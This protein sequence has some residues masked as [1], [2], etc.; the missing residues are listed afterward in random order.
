MGK[1]YANSG[2]QFFQTGDRSTSSLKHI[3]IQD[4]GN[5][6]S[7]LVFMTTSCAFC[8]F[9]IVTLCLFRHYVHT[10]PDSVPGASHD[11]LNAAAHSVE[12]F[13]KIGLVLGVTTGS[14]AIAGLTHKSKTPHNDLRH[15][16]HGKDAEE[17][18]EDEIGSESGDEGQLGQCPKELVDSDL[19]NV[20]TD[21]LF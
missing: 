18:T 13:L 21:A 20:E 5:F 10:H 15:Y 19:E 3:S 6:I 1:S 4:D 17:S 2:A 9:N 8:A 14:A 11:Q 12:Y 7:F 16:T